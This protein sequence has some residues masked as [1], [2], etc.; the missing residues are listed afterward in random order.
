MESNNQEDFVNQEVVDLDQE[1]Q[2]NNSLGVG[3]SYECVFCKR[4]FNTAQALGGHMNIHRK[5][6]ARN[7]PSSSSSL[8]L[9]LNS[10][11]DIISSSNHDP[12]FYHQINIIPTYHHQPHFFPSHDHQQQFMNHR[13][14]SSSSSNFQYSSVPAQP[15]SPNDHYFNYN[16]QIGF[17]PFGFDQW[18]MS[19]HN[20]MPCSS[21]AH[22][23]DLEKSRRGVSQEE[24]LDL[25]LR[26]GGPL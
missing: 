18:S 13:S 22:V 1:D 24:E 19:F 8:D 2:D 3:R 9:V 16:H 14:S 10:S 26:L 23:E 4:G 6:R 21:S 25:E 20:N 11:N 12:R 5:D 15:F 7:K 17:N